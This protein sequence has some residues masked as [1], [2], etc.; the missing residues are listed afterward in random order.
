MIAPPHRRHLD[1]D[2]GYEGLAGY[3]SVGRRRNSDSRHVFVRFGVR[4]T[5][6]SRRP[7]VPGTVFLRPWDPCRCRRRP[8]KKRPM[9]GGANA[10]GR[11]LFGALW[12]LHATRPASGR[13]IQ[14]SL[15]DSGHTSVTTWPKASGLGKLLMAPSD[16]LGVRNRRPKRADRRAPHHSLRRARVRRSIGFPPRTEN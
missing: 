14:H 9:R 7:A 2:L 16:V 8:T 11:W 15:I 13:G 10:L 5:S 6:Q 1:S 3:L 12:L 4:T